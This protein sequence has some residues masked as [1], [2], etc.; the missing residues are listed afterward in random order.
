MFLVKLNSLSEALSDGGID[1]YFLNKNANEGYRVYLPSQNF[2]YRSSIFYL[3]T[4]LTSYSPET[5]I[6]TYSKIC[7]NT[8]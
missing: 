8:V 2:N 6:I 4:Y 3:S 7:L 5:A 1:M